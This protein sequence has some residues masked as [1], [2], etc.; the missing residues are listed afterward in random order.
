MLDLHLPR[1]N[2][3]IPICNE[4]DVISLRMEVRTLARCSGF[5]LHEQ[6]RISLAASTIAHILGLGTPYSGCLV[7]R[8]MESESQPALQLVYTIQGFPTSQVSELAFGQVEWMVDSLEI[9]VPQPDQLTV[10][11]TKFKG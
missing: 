9:E 11:V 8:Y 3:E 4:R 10:I 1:Q 2:Q 7:Y 6:A 5:D